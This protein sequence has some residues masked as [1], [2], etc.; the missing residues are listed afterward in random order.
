MSVLQKLI[1]AR[2]KH[3]ERYLEFNVEEEYKFEFIDIVNWCKNESKNKKPL[4]YWNLEQKG[5]NPM[6]QLIKNIILMICQI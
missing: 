1:Y 2:E 5:V 6:P 3:I 4:E